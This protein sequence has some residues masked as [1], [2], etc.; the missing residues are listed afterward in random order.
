MGPVDQHIGELPHFHVVVG[1]DIQ[2]E[3]FFVE[4]DHHMAVL[5]IKTIRDFFFY[6]VD[7]IIEWL[8]IQLY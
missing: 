7:R 6:H 1:F 4:V 5:E 2:F 8:G 3:F